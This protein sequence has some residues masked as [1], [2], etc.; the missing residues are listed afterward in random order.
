MDISR[1]PQRTPM[2]WS[3]SEHAGFTSGNRTWL[4]VAAN[5][6]DLNVKVQ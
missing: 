5:Y 6:K 1:D 4:P 3:S 2:Q